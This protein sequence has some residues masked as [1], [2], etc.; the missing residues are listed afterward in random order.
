M[1]PVTSVSVSG[2][3]ISIGVRGYKT[4]AAQVTIV[5]LVGA[6]RAPIFPIVTGL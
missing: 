5:G 2:Y 6:N 1:L 4:G 3:S